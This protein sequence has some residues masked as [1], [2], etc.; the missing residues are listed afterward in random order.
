[1]N[2][3][4]V[5]LVVAFLAGALFCAT[6][7]R[8]SSA[9]KPMI[10]HNPDGTFTVQKEPVKRDTKDAKAKKELIIPPQVVVPIIP[11]PEKKQ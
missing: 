7:A 6:A 3:I 11:A 2:R 10:T 8:A 4:P 9:D 5:L 1:M